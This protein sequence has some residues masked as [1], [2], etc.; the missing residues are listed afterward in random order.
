ME[1]SF[2]IASDVR[3]KYSSVTNVAPQ[4]KGYMQHKYCQE[5]GIWIVVVVPT[6]DMNYMNYISIINPMELIITSFEKV[7]IT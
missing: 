3:R 6:A 4:V 5:I 2:Y 7:Y 1:L